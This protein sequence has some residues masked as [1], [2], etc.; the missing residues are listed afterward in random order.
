MRAPKRGRRACAFGAIAAPVPM[1]T[2][3]DLGAVG[4]GERPDGRA[5]GA[6]ECKAPAS[7][8]TKNE[9]LKISNPKNF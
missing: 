6:R 7:L 5:T 3:E 8:K 4:A 1:Y 2:C 9:K